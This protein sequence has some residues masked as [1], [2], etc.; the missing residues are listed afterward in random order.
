MYRLGVT[1]WD[2]AVPEELADLVTGPGSLAPGRA[3]DLG[4][5]SGTKAIFIASHGWDV[6]AVESV[7]RAVA[8]ARRR[9]AAAGADIDFRQADVTRLGELEL[10]PGYNLV[11]DFGCYHG[12][13]S[14]QRDAYA[15]GVS[16]LVAGGATLLLMGFA[17]A[18]Y[19]VPLPVTEADLIQRLG[20]DWKVAWSHPQRTAGTAAMNRSAA[21]WF[22]LTHS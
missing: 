13:S 8:T 22:C 12:L 14:A 15:R 18:Q 20:Q 10:E 7:P 21:T 16:S 17:K 6:T 11:F 1:P 9:A 4:S 3:L 19:P 5:G 2:G